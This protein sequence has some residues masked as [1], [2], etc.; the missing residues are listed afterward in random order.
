MERIDM[1]NL[2]MKTR[3]L[4]STLKA[5][6]TA[7]SENEGDSSGYG[8]AVFNLALMSMEIEE[9]LDQLVNPVKGDA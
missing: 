5:V 7:L 4:S 6:Q 2:L 9:A 8:W 3:I 1:E